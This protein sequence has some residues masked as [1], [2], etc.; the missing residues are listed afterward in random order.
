M[1][2]SG[3]VS[4]SCVPDSHFSEFRLVEADI[5]FYAVRLG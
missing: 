3:P 4:L 1:D 2:A 5:G